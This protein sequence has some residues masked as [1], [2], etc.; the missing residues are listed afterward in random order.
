V[1][2]PSFCFPRT[3]DRAA[4]EVAH[5]W[6][7]RMSFNAFFAQNIGIAFTGFDVPSG[8]VW[9]TQF[10]PAPR[11]AAHRGPKRTT[12][13]VSSVASAPIKSRSNCCAIGQPF[14]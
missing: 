5:C 8:G 7:W 9:D 6:G 11:T 13:V 12:T 2:L 3:E 10:G 1:F 4:C 14:P